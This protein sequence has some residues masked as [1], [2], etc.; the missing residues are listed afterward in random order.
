[1]T[2]LR[3]RYRELLVLRAQV[4][5]A[6]LEAFVKVAPVHTSLIDADATGFY[7][8]L[9]GPW[10]TQREEERPLPVAGDPDQ[11]TSAWGGAPAQVTQHEEELALQKRDEKA[12]GPWATP[13]SLIEADALVQK[14]S[15]QSFQS[16][17][18]LSD[19]TLEEVWNRWRDNL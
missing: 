19:E 14:R 13:R 4:A 15:S 16:F 2:N 17:H 11:D 8:D 1:M 10:A 9:D 5:L 7:A 12:Q 6:E 18:A 3:K